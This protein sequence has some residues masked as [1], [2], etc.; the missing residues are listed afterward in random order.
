[1]LESVILSSSLDI[2]D[3][4]W[5]LFLRGNSQGDSGGA[6]SKQRTGGWKISLL[7]SGKAHI[8]AVKIRRMEM[9]ESCM[10]VPPRASLD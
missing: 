7:S 1:M 2:N 8:V 5:G 10:I 3:L 6:R 4:I 9:M